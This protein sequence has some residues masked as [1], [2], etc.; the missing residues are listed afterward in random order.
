MSRVAADLRLSPNSLSSKKFT[1]PTR[2]QSS[3]TNHRRQERARPQ[4]M[5]FSR[6]YSTSLVRLLSVGTNL[7]DLIVRTD[8]LSVIPAPKIARCFQGEG[9]A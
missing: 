9:Q 2:L 8:Y 7:L 6:E 4:K 3:L 1:H 5:T